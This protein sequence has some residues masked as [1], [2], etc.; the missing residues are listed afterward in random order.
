M[1]VISTWHCSMPIWTLYYKSC[2][3]RPP[4]CILFRLNWTKQWGVI[5]NETS[6][7]FDSNQQPCYQKLST[8]EGHISLLFANMKFWHISLNN[9]CTKEINRFKIIPVISIE[10]SFNCMHTYLIPVC[11][12]IGIFCIGPAYWAAN[13]MI[14]FIGQGEKLCHKCMYDRAIPVYYCPSVVNLNNKGK[15]DICVHLL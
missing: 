13:W 5:K 10:L 4:L 6:P 11:F 12:K 1:L 2:G 9:M 3:F 15:N 14:Q 7:W 8:I